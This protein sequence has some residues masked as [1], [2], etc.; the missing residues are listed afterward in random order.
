QRQ[1]DFIPR[2]QHQWLIFDLPNADFGSLNIAEDGDHC[3]FFCCNASHIIYRFAMRF[4]IAMR[5]INPRHVH[6]GADHLAKCIFVV[7]GRSNGSDDFGAF[8]VNA[9]GDQGDFPVGYWSR[10]KLVKA[11]MPAYFAALP[12]SSSILSS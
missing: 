2:F 1:G 5:E 7:G 10:C 3:I 12:S 9:V 11:W 8:P 4:M 6:S